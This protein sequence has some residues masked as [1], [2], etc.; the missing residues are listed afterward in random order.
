MKLIEDE[1]SNEWLGLTLEEYTKRFHGR[2]DD[3]GEYWKMAPIVGKLPISRPASPLGVAHADIAT[4]SDANAEPAEPETDSSKKAVG[5]TEN[6]PLGA[7][8][9][10][11]GDSFELMAT[12]LA[13]SKEKSGI[14]CL[15]G[16]S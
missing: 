5:I 3:L 4:E 10:A 8:K 12:G 6:D 2:Y 15:R 1:D 13:W 11:I 16:T 9:S 7:G 14:R